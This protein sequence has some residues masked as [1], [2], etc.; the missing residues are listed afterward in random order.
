MSQNQEGL[1]FNFHGVSTPFSGRIKALNNVP[2][3]ELIKGPPGAALSVAG[4][5][6]LST[7][8]GSNHGEWFKW[9]ATVAD[10]KGE[11]A[12]KNQFRTTC[13]AQIA[14]LQAKNDPFLFEADLIR[15]KMVSHHDGGPAGASRIVPA[16]MVFDGVR[17]NGQVIEVHHDND[18]SNFPTLTA[19]EK[20]YQT[21][22]AFFAK[23]CAHFK[24]AEADFGK[25]L[26]RTSGG[27]VVSTFVRGF[28]YQG[29]RRTGNTL[30]LKGFGTLHF[31]E[32]LQ[33]ADNRRVTMVRLEMGCAMAASSGAGEVD[34]NGTW[35]T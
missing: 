4:G 12:G 30:A 32:V 20:E 17:L 34:Q 25:A 29:E 24:Q 23:H 1:L 10:C 14:D 18:F 21:N 27:F 7:S 6:S 8:I 33:K 2:H 19:F 13:I 3:H 35:G 16:E 28:D 31:G 26:P 22:R 11:Q 5:W 15:L 9:G